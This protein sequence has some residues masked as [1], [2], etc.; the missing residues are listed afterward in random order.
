LITWRQASP[1]NETLFLEVVHTWNHDHAAK[2]REVI[3]SKAKVW[4]SIQ[5][6]IDID[7]EIF[8]SYP[9]RMLF[10]VAIFAASVALL[11]GLFIS[12]FV[13]YRLPQTPTYAYVET[14][15]GQ[16]THIILPDGTKV[17]LNS[18][19]KIAYSSDYNKHLRVV[20]LTGEAFFD[21]VHNSQHPFIV[22]TG[23]VDVKDLG[24]AF[25]I[26][27]YSNDSSIEVSLLRGSVSLKTAYDQTQIGML[28]PNQKA[29]INKSNL[30]CVVSDCNTADDNIWINNQIRFDG[31]TPE[32]MV[33]QLNRWFGVDIAAINVPKNKR[34]WFALKTESLTETLQ[35]INKITPINYII[36][37]EEVHVKFKP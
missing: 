13:F 1:K 22:N 4:S 21:V 37:G 7:N 32:E 29:T 11:V 10:Q 16:K 28:H 33:K 3:P 2:D 8:P 12:F 26:R 9:K 20:R 31:A 30:L 6:Q 36:N 19:S 17:W 23:K 27:A 18:G 14:P 15:A 24:T 25:D 5:S 34:Y 35:L